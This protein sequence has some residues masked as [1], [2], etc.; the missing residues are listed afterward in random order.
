M[1]KL[2]MVFIEEK[3]NHRSIWLCIP[4]LY[5]I[6]L[7]DNYSV[8]YS[9][10]LKDTQELRHLIGRMVKLFGLPYQRTITSDPDNPSVWKIKKHLNEMATYYIKKKNTQNIVHGII[11]SHVR[12]RLE[13]F[14]L[15]L[16]F[17][18]LP[19]K[20]IYNYF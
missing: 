9:T 16:C 15:I 4:P 1:K 19:K 8:K 12:L 5:A 11:N 3:K 18:S 14:K 2:N 13:T 17:N 10:I 6:I 7:P 20:Y